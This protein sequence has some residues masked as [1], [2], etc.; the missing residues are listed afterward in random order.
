M[1]TTA[2]LASDIVRLDLEI[3]SAEEAL[4]KLKARRENLG[5][6]L[7][8]QFED[9]RVDSLTVDVDGKKFT[10]YTHKQYWAKRKNG[11]E[12]EDVYDALITAGLDEYATRSYNTQ[13]V[14]AYLRELRKNDENAPLPEALAD[15]LDFAEVVKINVRKK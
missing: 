6:L 14:S 10:A 8:G 5:G 1:P 3:D 13:S 4:K 9:E 12:A 11:A 2:E 7:A 15:V